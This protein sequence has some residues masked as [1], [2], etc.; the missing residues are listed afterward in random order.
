MEGKREKVS[1][2]ERLDN[3]VDVV[4]FQLE[5]VHTGVIAWLLDSH[6][7]PLSRGQRALVLTKLIGEQV[8]EAD[9]AEVTETREY[10]FGRRMRVDLVLDLGGRRYVVVE[11][12]TDSDVREDQLRKTRDAFPK[13]RPDAECSF[14]LVALG[15]S[16]FT[17][18]PGHMEELG[19]R[20]IDVPGAL[21]IF[22]GLS[23]K[24]NRIYDDWIDALQRE[25]LR[26][27]NIDK[28]LAGIESPWDERLWRQGYRLGFPVF[29][30]YY[31]KLRQHLDRGEFKAWSISSGANNPEMSWDAGWVWLKQEPPE[32]QLGLFWEFNWQSLILKAE[33][34][35]RRRDAWPRLAEEVRRLCRSSA[36]GGREPRARK[37]RWMSVWKWDFDFCHDAV[38]E[39]CATTDKVLASVHKKLAKLG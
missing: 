28:A 1:W 14:L 31:D 29:Y 5:K 22:S 36:V 32:E 18:R 4:G 37:G 38:S 3:F 24:G 25:D 2:E 9:A 13:A 8:A 34:G 7:S 23:V 10:S 35:A 15:A 16:Q 33:V 19:W 6:S 17:Y 26:C 30:A 11:C 39:V 20:A 27:S 21:R 12:K